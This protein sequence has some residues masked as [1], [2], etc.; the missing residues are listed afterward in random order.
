[1]AT[2]K[3][4][5]NEEIIEAEVVSSGKSNKNEQTKASKSMNTKESINTKNNYNSGRFFWGMV[6]VVMG[7]MFALESYLEINVWQNFWPIIIV[8][9]GISIIVASF[10]NKE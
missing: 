4:V 2:T 10:N 5:K 8:I 6:L 9:I 1:M 3:K 7:L